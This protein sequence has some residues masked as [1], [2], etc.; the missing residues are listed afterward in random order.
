MKD[1][2][3]KNQTEKTETTVNFSKTETEPKTYSFFCKTE[4]KTKLRTFFANCTPLV[5]SSGKQINDYDV[6]SIFVHMY[7]CV[8]VDSR[9]HLPLMIMYKGLPTVTTMRSVTFFY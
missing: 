7:I 8:Y 9:H 6:I 5:S 1:G 4:P 2:V 3:D